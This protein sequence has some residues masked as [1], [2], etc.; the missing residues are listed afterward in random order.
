[1]RR[2]VQSGLTVALVG[3][4]QCL[5]YAIMSGLPPAYGL[6]TAAVPGVVA[7]L[8]GKSDQIVTGPTNTTGLL[9]LAAL[10]PYLAANGLIGPQGLPVLA[11]LTLLAGLIR[12]AVTFVGGASVVD[13]LPESV[14]VGFATGAGVLIAAMQ[15]DEALGMTA[16]HGGNLVSVAAAFSSKLL[17]GERPA[18]PAV[19]VTAL[20]V[21]AIALGRKWRP[22]WPIALSVVVL[23]AGFALATGINQASGL[24]LVGDRARVDA[25]W[26][27]GALPTLDLGVWRDLFVPAAAIVLIGTLELTVAARAF[28]ARP[29]MA[30]EVRA[31][32]FA[33]VIGAFTSAFPASASLTRSVLLKLGGAQSRVAAAIA[34]VAVVPLLFVAAPLVRAIPLASLAGVLMITAASMIR[35]EQIRRMWPFAR[36]TRILLAV[37]FVATITL[38]LEWAILGGAGLGLAIHLA[39]TTHVRFE[40]RRLEG[41]VLVLVGTDEK[42]RAIVVEVSGNLHYAAI[43]RFLH[44]I[45][46]RIPAD[47]SLLVIDLSH[48]HSMRYAAFLAFEELQKR[49]RER[50]AKVVLAGVSPSFMAMLRQAHS[51]LTVYEYDPTPSKSAI[52]ALKEH[53]PT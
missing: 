7:A 20:T 32:G 28:G 29:D 5:A 6:A 19:L 16:V 34:A 2:N 15:L 23:G 26:P 27:P 35:I 25:G 3:L 12:L 10:G 8:V 18:W 44:E 50:G 42:P 46:S 22:R 30:R 36:P 53:T 43:R 11:T 9:I 41:D 40:L 45:E 48:A 47:T 49:A 1:L 4:P 17:G 33:N 51:E 52:R 31:Q 37:T 24:P 21:I 38:P 39:E 14:L 13:F